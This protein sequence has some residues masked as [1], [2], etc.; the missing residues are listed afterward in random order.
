MEDGTGRGEGT[1]LLESNLAGEE[2][3]GGGEG[4]KRKLGFGREQR[5]FELNKR[6]RWRKGDFRKYVKGR[7]RLARDCLK[8]CIYLVSQY[9]HL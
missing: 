4:T 7:T 5:D 9:G 6:R 1:E 8:L 2:G 3:G